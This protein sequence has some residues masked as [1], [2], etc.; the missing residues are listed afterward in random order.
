MRTGTTYYNQDVL[1]I[2]FSQVTSLV[3]ISPNVIQTAT[4]I[5]QTTKVSSNTNILISMILPVRIY[6]NSFIRIS[7]PLE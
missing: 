2:P 7:V 6:D 4:F 5:R 1:D 3:S